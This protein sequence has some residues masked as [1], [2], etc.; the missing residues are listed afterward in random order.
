MVKCLPTV[1]EPQVSGFDPQT[2][3]EH[4]PLKLSSFLSVCNSAL[5]SAS[6]LLQKAFFLFCFVF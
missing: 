6:P 4:V 2:R 5:G 1:L 3:E